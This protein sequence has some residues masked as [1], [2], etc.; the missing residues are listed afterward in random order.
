[1]KK[2][3]GI[4]AFI[5]GD[6]ALENGDDVSEKAIFQ[7]SSGRV[8]RNWPGQETVCVEEL[9]RQGKQLEPG[10]EAKRKW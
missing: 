3:K 2:S 10:P 8:G 9:S 7:L 4:R 6:L 5:T 1:M